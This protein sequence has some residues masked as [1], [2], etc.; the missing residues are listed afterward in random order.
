MQTSE[1]YEL[2]AHETAAFVANAGFEEVVIGLSGGIDSA[3]VATIAVDALGAQNVHGVLL[4]GPYS[5][6]H[7]KSDASAL[8]DNLGIERRTIDISDAYSAFARGYADSMN[9]ALGGLAAENTQARCRMVYLMAIS[10][11]RGYLMLNTSNKSEAAMGYSTLYGDTAGAFS[12]IGGLYKTTVY[13]LAK[14]RNDHARFIGQTPPIPKNILTKA[15]SAELSPHQSDEASMGIDYATLDKILI[16]HI[17]DGQTVDEICHSGFD[18]TQ[19]QNVVNRY[20]SYAYKR[21]MEPPFPTAR[22]YD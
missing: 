14:W 4:P 11:A 19:V 18:R 16:A 9:E 17:E 10:N 15:P 12:P 1:I 5:T 13:E 21:A 22:I 3:L 8:A 20:K 7:S 6:D 2:C